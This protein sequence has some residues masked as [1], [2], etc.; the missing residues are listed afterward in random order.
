[1]LLYENKKPDASQKV[2]L[3]GG[4]MQWLISGYMASLS[5]YHMPAFFSWIPED[6]Y[7]VISVMLFYFMCWLRY[8]N[9]L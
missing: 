1:M 7:V 9:S 8:A 6:E 2:V 5:L 3:I 4:V